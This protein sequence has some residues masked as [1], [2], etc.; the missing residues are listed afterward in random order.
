MQ[1]CLRTD[2]EVLCPQLGIALQVRTIW[3]PASE[4]H[5]ILDLPLV[6]ND[7]LVVCNCGQ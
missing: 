7:D 5:G 1:F 6:L 4:S 2:R 3:H